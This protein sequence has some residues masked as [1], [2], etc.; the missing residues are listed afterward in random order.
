L[1]TKSIDFCN[2]CA[3]SESEDCASDV[4]FDPIFGFLFDFYLANPAYF[5][6]DISPLIRK[7]HRKIITNI[8]NRESCIRQIK[9]HSHICGIPNTLLRKIYGMDFNRSLTHPSSL[10]KQRILHL[11][12]LQHLT[13]IVHVIKP[14]LEV[15]RDARIIHNNSIN[16]HIEL[17]VLIHCRLNWA[18]HL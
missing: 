8:H 12:E 15:L 4:G 7:S 14:N 6:Q 11:T 10:C 9:P 16:L 17:G 2:D 18:V 1:S 13:D 3:A 5:C